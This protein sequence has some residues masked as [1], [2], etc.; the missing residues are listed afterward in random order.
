[1]TSTQSPPARLATFDCALVAEARCRATP[2]D[3]ASRRKSPDPSGR[4]AVH[5][6]L[7][8]HA[9]EQTV[10]GVA[11]VFGAILG[12][13]LDPEGFG[14]W[15][16]L[17][18]PHYLGRVAFERAFP[19]FQAEGAWGVSPHLIPAHSLHSPSGTLSQALKAHGPNLGIG[20]T[21]AGVRESLLVASTWLMTGTVPGVWVVVTGREHESD[22]REPAGDYEA[23]ALA[24]TPA[25][26]GHL[27]PRLRVSPDE[28]A[29][30]GLA[31]AARI[32]LARWLKPGTL[33]ADAPRPS[34]AIPRPHFRPGRS[35]REIE[36]NRDPEARHED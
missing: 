20:G 26:A 35:A 34:G 12:A 27:G 16:V 14:A 17:A 8:R 1:M 9:D 4:I 23:L 3:I 18:A 10:A 13:G 21:P 36:P 31:D 11:A 6:S 22:G 7:L 2:A 5:P 33:R 28:V 15:A 19:T 24:L 29:P 25:P 32:D 30:L